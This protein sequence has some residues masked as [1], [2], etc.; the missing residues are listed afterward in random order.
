VAILASASQVVALGSRLEA[1]R[2]G[3]GADGGVGGQGILGTTGTPG[4]SRDCQQKACRVT[5]GSC[6]NFPNVACYYGDSEADQIN[7]AALGGASGGPGG[8]GA[9]GQAG[10]AGAGGPSISVVLLN[11]ATLSLDAGTVL[12]FRGGGVGGAGARNGDSA[13]VRSY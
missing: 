10:G 1:G 9:T 4:M 12:V 7:L 11:G 5:T 8:R 2:G 13:P 3:N 6:A